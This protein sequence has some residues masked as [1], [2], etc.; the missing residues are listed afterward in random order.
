ML[1]YDN[2]SYIEEDDISLFSSNILEPT[3]NSVFEEEY[4]LDGENQNFSFEMDNIYKEL[5]ENNNI[6]HKKNDRTNEQTNK[7]FFTVT[8]DISLLNKKRYRN[9][10]SENSTGENSNSENILE[11]SE[12]NDEEGI[13]INSEN[14]DISNNKNKKHNRYCTDNVINKLKGYLFNHFLIDIVKKNSI[15][16]DIILK[17]LPNKTFIADLNKKKNEQLFKMKMADILRQEKISSKYSKYDQYYNRKIIDEIYEE[18]KEKN[19]IKILELTFEELFIIFRRKLK[20]KE[21]MKKL[22]EMKDKIEG[23]DLNEINNK[24]EDIEWLINGIKK[25]YDN[26]LNED[27]IEY[28]EQLKS[29]CLGYEDWFN[30]KIARII[31]KFN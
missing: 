11:N 5:F 30:N 22:E 15:K 12:N 7:I 19:V 18:N 3:E 17:K 27:E 31:K 14:K 24:Y 2:F 6:N 23:L 9:D 4:I 28:I 10:D 25:K 20:D 1:S 16:K 8:K 21:D 29:L 26:N 13:N